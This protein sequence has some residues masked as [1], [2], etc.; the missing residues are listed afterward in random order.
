MKSDWED[1]SAS[2]LRIR[3][4]EPPERALYLDH[5]GDQLYGVLHTARGS[6]RATVLLAGPFG[7]ERERAYPTCVR[8]ARR[9]AAAGC[10]VLRFD[11]R[12][13]GESSGRFE[14]M[15]LTEWK[16]DVALLSSALRQRD[17]G[18][19]H[20]LQGVRLGALLAAERFASGEADGLLLWSAPGGAREHLWET[21]RRNLM[22]EMVLAL[23]ARPRTREEQVAELEAGS[24]VNVDGYFWT[25]ELWSD[26]AQHPL[27]LPAAAESR[28]WHRF[29]SAALPAVG[30]G[31]HE[32]RLRIPS[33]WESGARM[34]LPCEALFEASVDWLA[35]WGAADRGAA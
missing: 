17:P 10:D 7:A 3:P 9:L 33:F 31:P 28:A 34:I 14:S 29:E 26:A 22:A 12:G 8:W 21:L 25:R 27:T 35:T 6:R 13:I 5:R 30:D 19:P 2:A 4:G 20:V 32:T 24:A 23:Q 11:Y 15:T 16:A 18:V 1:S